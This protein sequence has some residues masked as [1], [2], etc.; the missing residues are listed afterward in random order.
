MDFS[1]LDSFLK[2]KTRALPPRR[3]PYPSKGNRPAVTGGYDRNRTKAPY[4]SLPEVLKEILEEQTRQFK[5]YTAAKEWEVQK[6]REEYPAFKKFHD[7]IKREE[8]RTCLIE[9]GLI[10]LDLA[11]AIDKLKLASLPSPVRRMAMSLC[12]TLERKVT[13]RETGF[14]F[15]DPLPF[16]QATSTGSG[17]K[18]TPRP[19][20]ISPN[21][22][23]LTE[24]RLALCLT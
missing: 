9:P 24:C 12:T 19:P 22:G 3:P 17:K 4:T 23:T 10:D 13:Q 11:D 5:A 14:P 16:P 20:S 15:N 2:A 6:Y 21:S 18:S 1:G 8:K 7:I